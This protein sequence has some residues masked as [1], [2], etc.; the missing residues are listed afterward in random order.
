MATD[1]N[2]NG[3]EVVDNGSA[4]KRPRKLSKSINVDTGELT[5]TYLGSDETDTFNI[6]DYP[7]TI[8]A[9]LELHGL[10]Q[11]LGDTGAGA[12]ASALRGLV[13]ERNNALRSGTWSEGREIDRTTLIEAYVAAMARKGKRVKRDVVA[14]H[15]NGLDAKG[16]AQFKR[17][18][19][20]VFELHEMQRAK[21]DAGELDLPDIG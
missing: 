10:A 8:R 2:G 9:R 13:A 6:A 1:E 5:F 18:P 4:T 20:I 17:N 11:V 14:A 3:G 19:A 7:A 15:V 21:A 12:D 16:A